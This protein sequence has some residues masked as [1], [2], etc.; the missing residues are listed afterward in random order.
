MPTGVYLSSGERYV[1]KKH[2]RR[3]QTNVTFSD[4]MK[5]AAILVTLIHSFKLSKILQDLPLQCV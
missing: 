4:Q 3:Y 1:W 2:Q 5:M